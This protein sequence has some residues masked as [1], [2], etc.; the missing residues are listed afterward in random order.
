MEVSKEIIKLAEKIRAYRIDTKLIKEIEIKKEILEK[1]VEELEEIIK[2]L[3]L[4]RIEQNKLLSEIKNL[5][6][7]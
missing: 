6:R 5:R 7:K 1:H 2:T 4:N 3:K